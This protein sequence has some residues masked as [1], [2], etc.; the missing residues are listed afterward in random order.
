MGNYTV[1]KRVRALNRKELGELRLQ[2]GIPK[3]VHRHLQRGG[4]P[5]ITVQ[6]VSGSWSM[7]W[8]CGLSVYAFIDTQLPRALAQQE[9]PVE[10][11][12]GSTVADFAH[13]FNMLYT[14]ANVLGD[15]QFQEDK[16]RAFKAYMGRVQQPHE[17]TPDEKAADDEVLED[18]EKDDKARATI[19]DMAEHIGK[20]VRDGE[21]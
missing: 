20:E 17:E 12:D 13:W 9:D 8:V 16:A 15:A 3:D 7:F 18:L 19:V 6:T 11:Y 5:Y 21:Q 2:A 14:D 10:G 4:L 1:I